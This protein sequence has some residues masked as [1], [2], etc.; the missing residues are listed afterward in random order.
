MGRLSC[1]VFAFWIRTLLLAASGALNEAS[2]VSLS[3]LQMELVK[4]F[5]SM[6]VLVNQTRRFFATLIFK[7]WLCKKKFFCFL[8]LLLCILTSDE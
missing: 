8:L 1:L 2:E 3:A 7:I 6:I 5:K 4:S